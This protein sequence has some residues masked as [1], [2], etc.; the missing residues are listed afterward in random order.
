M[1]TVYRTALRGDK[2]AT[3]AGKP[4]ANRAGYWRVNEEGMQE[5]LQEGIRQRFIL[6]MGTGMEA[7][8]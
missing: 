8:V 6:E 3:Q 7:N 1:P 4:H 2:L 5:G